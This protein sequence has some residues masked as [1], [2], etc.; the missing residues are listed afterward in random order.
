QG[1]EVGLHYIPLHFLTYYK[2]KY[3]LKVNNF[4][5]ALTTYQQVMSLPIYASMEDKEVQYVIEKIKAVAST[6]V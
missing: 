2:N 4:P 6:R 1:V 3:S 5:V